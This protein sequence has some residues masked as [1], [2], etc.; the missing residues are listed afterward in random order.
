MKLR[1]RSVPMIYQAESSECALACL[2]MVGARHGMDIPLLEL[3]ERFP[4]SLK[5]ST[6]RD[7]VELADKMEL[8]ARSVRCEMSDLPRLQLPALLHWDFEHFVVLVA[9][10]GDI[11]TIHDPAHGVL[12]LRLA[13]VSH[14]FTGIA[15]ELAPRPACT[16]QRVDKRF[17]LAALLRHSRGVFGYAGQVLWITLFLELFALLSPLLL[18]TVIDTG[19]ARQ[20]MGFIAA[21]TAGFAGVALLHG[22]VALARDYVL[23]HFGSSFNAQFMGMLI[24]RMMRLPLGFYAKRSIGDLV[25]RYQ[26]TN[27][28]RQILT[29][30]LPRVLLDGLIALV[31][32]GIIFA[33]SP[34]LAGIALGT[35]VLYLAVRLCLFKRMRQ[36]TEEAVKARSEEN[37]H[38]IETLRGMQP[39]K[40][41][42]KEHERLGAWSNH[43]SRLVN[44]DIRAG[45]MASLQGASK[46]TLLGLDMAASVY[47]GATQVAAGSISLGLLF[48]LFVYKAH[49]ATKAMA[50]AEQT[51]ELRLVGLHMDRLSEIA[52]S[53]IEQDPAESRGVPERMKQDFTIELVDISAR[54][55]PQEKPVLRNVSLKVQQGDFIALTGPSG[56]G[57]TTLFKALLGLLELE[58]GQIRI[59]GEDIQGYDLQQYRRLFGVVMQE[60]MLLSGSILDNIA[61]FAS[62]PDETRARHCA[63]AALILDDIEAMPMKFNSRIGDLGSTLSGGQK[64]RILLARALYHEPRILLLDEGTANLDEALERRLLDNLAGLGITCVSI[65]HRPETIR[66]AN[67]VYHVEAAT[68]RLPPQSAA[69]SPLTCAIP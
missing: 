4:I 58:S 14:H 28:V 63:D 38:V 43:Y 40:I 27:A 68:V 34:A 26:S 15:V 10:R 12:R 62:S 41:F 16:V 35:F 65:A 37:S 25:D 33:M 52:V 53:P 49:F 54:F 56:S 3:R 60:D 42:A 36:L 6:L 17:T 8:D 30:A 22:A 18:K 11:A 39:I 24:Q 59:N 31:A 5:G 21:I 7:V 23:L 50:L 9:A 55:A 69:P 61:F 1:K 67:R 32:L 51:M 66:R 48:A 45:L 64:Q 47:V 19:L 29:G 46:V 44:A 57:K 13:D 20:D 2:A